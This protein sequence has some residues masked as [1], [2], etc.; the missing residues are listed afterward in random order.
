MMDSNNNCHGCSDWPDGNTAGWI[1]AG[2]ALIAGACETG[3]PGPE[4]MGKHSAD[5][6]S[7]DHMGDNRPLAECWALAMAAEARHAD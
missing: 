3:C 7:C 4:R 5:C 6:E 2:A 1:A